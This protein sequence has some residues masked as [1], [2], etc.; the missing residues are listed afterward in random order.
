M[1]DEVESGKISDDKNTS[2]I[3]TS[4]EEMLLYICEQ[5]SVNLANVECSWIVDSGASFQLTPKRECF[6]SY[7][8]GDY[9]YVR[10]G[11]ED[12]CKIVGIGNVCLLTSNSCRL[13]L[14]D[15]CHVP[16]V[17]LN[18]ISVGRL[19]DEGYSGGFQNGTWKFCQRSLIVARAQKTKHTLCNACKIVPR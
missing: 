10:M 6:S 2:A 15:V 7:I 4:E 18:L 19:D 9:G 1:T 5:A 17:R 14:K 13:K 16:D 8:A 12:E 3:A 11:N